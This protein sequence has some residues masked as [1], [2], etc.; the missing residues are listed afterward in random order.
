MHRN[1]SLHTCTNISGCTVI[2]LEICLSNKR[3]TQKVTVCISKADRL[4]A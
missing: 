2:N 3:E 4:L 1:V